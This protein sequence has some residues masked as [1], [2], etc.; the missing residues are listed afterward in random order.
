MKVCSGQTSQTTK[1]DLQKCLLISPLVEFDLNRHQQYQADEIPL[2]T[3]SGF[4]GENT[5]N[6][7]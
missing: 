3:V 1:S 7:M 4:I 2:R 5:R 6:V